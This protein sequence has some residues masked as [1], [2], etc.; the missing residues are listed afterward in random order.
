MEE[1]EREG[2]RKD[3]NREYGLRTENMNKDNNYKPQEEIDAS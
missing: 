1:V 3:W 2:E